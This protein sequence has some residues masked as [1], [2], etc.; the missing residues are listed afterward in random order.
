MTKG[1][2]HGCDGE[3]KLTEAEATAWLR[4]KTT[5]YSDGNLIRDSLIQAGNRSLGQ[6]VF[7]VASTSR[8]AD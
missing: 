1:A 6:L 8:Q 4:S 3:E 5:S 2:D 7:D